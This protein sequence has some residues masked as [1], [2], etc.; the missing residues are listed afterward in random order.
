MKSLCVVGTF[1]D[2]NGK[3]SK[4]GDIIYRSVKRENMDYINGGF[5]HDLQDTL[6]GVKDYGLIYWFANVPNDKEKLVRQIKEKNNACVLVT[7]KRNV[8]KNYDFQSLIY[9][10]LEIKSNLFVEFISKDGR[11]HGRIADPLANVF[12]DYTD[13]VSLIGKILKTRAEELLGYTRVPSIKIDERLDVPDEAE[14]FEI[15]K[16]YAG[17]FHDLI[18]A[19]PEATNRFFG[20]AS[21]RCERGFPAF[22]RGDIIYV[23]RRNVDKRYINRDS[24]VAVKAGQIPVNYF[25]DDKP[26]TD[27]PINVK[28]YSYY[29]NIKYI[30]HSHTNVDKTPFTNRIIPCGSLEEG[31][32]I[33]SLYPDKNSTNFHVNL[34]GHGSL[35]LA[36][37]IGFMKK[38]PYIS[39]PMPDY[40]PE[41]AS[42][43]VS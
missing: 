40:H 21:F 26:S 37:D 5:F 9:R 20:N 43:S 14:F 4:I 10:A 34:R 33:T 29:P 23:S 12:L 30:L 3:F 1:D 18:H 16:H 11:Y 24:F 8:D 19:H 25:G 35:T 15:I 31:D 38:I 39:R 2:N 7:S 17:V 28:L 41:Y 42:I 13:D 32:E 36:D 22:R 6:Y 27:T